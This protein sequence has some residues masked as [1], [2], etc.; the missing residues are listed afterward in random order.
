M[1]IK[2]KD[3]E[4]DYKEYFLIAMEH[5]NKIPNWIR[6]L[7]GVPTTPKWIIELNKTLK[8]DRQ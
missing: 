3:M 2:N 6:W 7:Y 5:L 8:N 1:N 4:R